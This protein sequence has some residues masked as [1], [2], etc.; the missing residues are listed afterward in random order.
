MERDKT[1][2]PFHNQKKSYNNNNS[3]N[4]GNNLPNTGNSL[5][6]Q[7]RL[8]QQQQQQQQIVFDELSSIV[9][10]FCK[11]HVRGQDFI[12]FHIDSLKYESNNQ[13]FRPPVKGLQIIAQN[14]CDRESGVGADNVLVITPPPTEQLENADFQL[15]IFNSDGSLAENCSTGVSCVCKYIID[16]NLQSYRSKKSILLNQQDTEMGEQ[17]NSLIEISNNNNND[18]NTFF[19][20]SR[21]KSLN[22]TPYLLF[23]P[24]NISIYTMAGIQHC[25]T[26]PQHPKNNAKTL[27]IKV[28]LGN[29]L[30]LKTSDCNDPDTASLEANVFQHPQYNNDLISYNNDQF[31]IDSNIF[32]QCPIFK[33]NQKNTIG[34]INNRILSTNS[35]YEDYSKMI[36]CGGHFINSTL[37]SMG[38]PHCV[39]HLENVEEFPLDY[40]GKVIESHPIFPQKTNV[41]FVEVKNRDLLRVRVWQRGIGVTHSCGTGAAAALVSGVLRGKNNRK[42]NVQMDGGTLEV[43]WREEDDRVFIS[44]PAITVFQGTIKFFQEELQV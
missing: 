31:E 8:Q 21:F 18:L 11:M 44:C 42:A 24:R 10:N 39:L 1:K 29:P 41:E 17:S 15:L 37:V 27:W 2:C 9:L 33:L 43:E 19:S 16:Y 20:K 12:V 26:Q 5:L 14:L 13:S 40:Y 22:Q 4:G 23:E 7:Q 32:Q 38:N 30:V 6:Q 35:N 3:G 25:I 28:S 34:K 36:Q